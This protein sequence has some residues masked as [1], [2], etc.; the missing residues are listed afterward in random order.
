MKKIL[1]ALLAIITITTFVSCS[2]DSSNTPQENEESVYSYTEVHGSD[3]FTA[4][5]TAINGNE[6]ELQFDI[7]ANKESIENFDT[8]KDMTNLFQAD[9]IWM[10]AEEWPKPLHVGEEFSFIIIGYGIQQNYKKPVRVLAPV[11]FY[12]QPGSDIET[13]VYSYTKVE[14]ENEIIAKVSSPFKDPYRKDEVRLYIDWEQNKDAIE[15]IPQLSLILQPTVI[16]VIKAKDWPTPL[17]KGDTIKFKMT[18]FGLQQNYRGIFFELQ[19]VMFY[20]EPCLD[21]K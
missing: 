11:R 12:I 14:V 4:K 1:I 6:V 16:N 17:K 10:K 20:I 7:E 5:V 13:P 15:K 3:G 21:E 9:R 8:N 19:P 18:G 2:D